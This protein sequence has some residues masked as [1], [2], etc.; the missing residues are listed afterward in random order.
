VNFE[1]RFLLLKS[2]KKRPFHVKAS[3]AGE[4]IVK[5]NDPMLLVNRKHT[6]QCTS[7]MCLRV[8]FGKSCRLR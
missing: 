3:Q 4:D 8:G 5:F 7:K 1:V 2:V 6:F